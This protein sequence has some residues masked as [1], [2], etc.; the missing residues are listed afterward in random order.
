MSAL[1]AIQI[2]GTRFTDKYLQAKAAMNRAAYSSWSSPYAPATPPRSPSSKIPSS[3]KTAVSSSPPRKVVTDF[4][5]FGAPANASVF[6]TAVASS[7]FSLAGGKAA[8]GGMRGS[9]GRVMFDDEDDEDDDN[10]RQRVE[11]KEDSITLDQVRLFPDV[12]CMHINHNERLGELQCRVHGE[13]REF[14]V[15]SYPN[16]SRYSLVVL[17]QI[18]HNGIQFTISAFVSCLKTGLLTCVVFCLLSTLFLPFFL[19]FSDRKSVV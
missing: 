3:P 19:P 6:G 16:C 9:G 7:P 11:L 18:L 2:Q 12:F 17:A 1:T 5:P 10:G 13:V 15:A 8:F 4:A 14:E